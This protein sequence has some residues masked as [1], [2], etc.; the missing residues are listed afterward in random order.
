MESM[1]Y[2]HIY[3]KEF[4]LLYIFLNFKYR[5]KFKH[6]SLLVCQDKTVTHLFPPLTLNQFIYLLSIWPV[7]SWRFNS[8]C[9]EYWVLWW[10][11]WLA[12]AHITLDTGPWLVNAGHVTRILASDWSRLMLPLILFCLVRADSALSLQSDHK[13]LH[14]YIQNR[15]YLLYHKSHQYQ[16]GEEI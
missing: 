5:S 10:R 9:I 2:V 16:F 6:C 1:K 8:W 13:I 14:K 7:I 3:K 4:G 15:K 11:Q 12:Q